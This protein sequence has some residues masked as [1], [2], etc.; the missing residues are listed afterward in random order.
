M[1]SKYAESECEEI[2]LMLRRGAEKLIRLIPV[3]VSVKERF[4]EQGERVLVTN[5]GFVCESFLNEENE[6]Q[7]GGTKLFF[8]TPTH[9]M[10]LPPPPEGSD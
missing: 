3:W 6:W 9:W 2:K 4:P 1:E 7:R 5:G 8:M 10:P